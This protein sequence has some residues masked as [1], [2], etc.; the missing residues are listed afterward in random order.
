M[1][2]PC[3]SPFLPE[4]PA[5]MKTLMRFSPLV[6]SPLPHTYSG[7]SE[8]WIL[9]HEEISCDSL[10]PPFPL[11]DS[12]LGAFCWVCNVGVF[13]KLRARLSTS[14]VPLQASHTP[15][16]ETDRDLRMRI[17]WLLPSHSPSL[18]LSLLICKLS[19]WTEYSPGGFRHPTSYVRGGKLE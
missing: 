6:G 15:C 3:P 9:E 4:P 13:L 12:L 10:S 1:P 14:C 16:K 8:S 11:P 18:N 2:F 17:V 19:R 5:E 7:G